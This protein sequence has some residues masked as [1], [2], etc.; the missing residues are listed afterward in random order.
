MRKTLVFINFRDFR[1]NCAILRSKK[2]LCL[3]LEAL[4]YGLFSE[5]DSLKMRDFLF[6]ALEKPS[7]LEQSLEILLDFTSLAFLY[8][9]KD[10]SFAR[11][12]A[13][14][15]YKLQE[16][17]LLFSQELLCNLFEKLLESNSFNAK[18]LNPNIFI[19]FLKSK[20]DNCLQNAEKFA[21]LC[22]KPR[23][24]ASCRGFLCCFFKA[25]AHCP[26]GF[27]EDDDFETYLSV[28]APYINGISTFL[29][30]FQ[31]FFEGNNGFL[32]KKLL[33]LLNCVAL[34]CENF[35]KILE[36][37]VKNDVLEQEKTEKIAVSRENEGKS[38][39]VCLDLFQIFQQSKGESPLKQPFSLLRMESAEKIDK[40]SRIFEIFFK[41]NEENQEN[42]S[43]ILIK[44]YQMEVFLFFLPNQCLLEKRLNDLM[45]LLSFS[46]ISFENTGELEGFLDVLL[47]ILNY[48]QNIA[49][50][51]KSEKLDNCKNSLDFGALNETIF[52]I[53]WKLFVSKGLCVN[54]LEN[55]LEIIEKSLDNETNYLS[56]LLKVLEAF[57]DANL[58]EERE[59]AVKTHEIYLFIVIFNEVFPLLHEETSDKAA[60][61]C[62]PL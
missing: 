26:A 30:D 23:F 39:E 58:M 24:F 10:A 46:E 41:E 50:I 38:G 37:V 62:D 22:E 6:L 33:F 28:L 54:K 27:A 19:G 16:N 8:E 52:Q 25:F 32:R 40:K 34:S 35:A 14:F 5:K 18:V 1:V 44:L 29:C 11:K 60:P 42:Y 2:V 21:S 43:E 59:N 55:Y 17:H 12:S 15:P 48:Q 4:I 36:I 49:D 9:R 51:I 3:L 20:A 53:L 61:T 13:A 7:F 45:S 56:I 31:R 47:K 57:A